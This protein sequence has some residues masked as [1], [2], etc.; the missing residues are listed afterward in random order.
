MYP[1]PDEPDRTYGGVKARLARRWTRLRISSQ[2]R[3]KPDAEP[4]ALRAS[5]LDR[6]RGRDLVF[7]PRR[8]HP[9]AAA[10]RAAA[11]LRFALVS[12]LGCARPLPPSLVP[13]AVWRAVVGRLHLN[14]WTSR[15]GERRSHLQVVA[16]AVQ[17]LDPPTKTADP[18]GAMAEAAEKPAVG[19]RR[20]GRSLLRALPGREGGVSGGD[21]KGRLTL[22]EHRCCDDGARSP[23]PPVGKHAPARS[24]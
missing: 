5:S 23:A 13:G 3:R 11:G 14:E 4:A 6:W 18:D 19:A 15:E 7:F 21:R 20:R 12:S 2:A 17:F 16:D 24:G 1:Q 22:Q 10:A 8:M 9:V